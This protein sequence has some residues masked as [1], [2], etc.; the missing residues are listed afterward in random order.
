MEFKNALKRE[1]KESHANSDAKEY[2]HVM[3]ETVKMAEVCK[4]LTQLGTG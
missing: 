3:M 1:I 4:I 2:H